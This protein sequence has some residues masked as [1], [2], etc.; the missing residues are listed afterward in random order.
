MWAVVIVIV[1]PPA[2]FLVEPV[3]VVADAVL[4]QQLVKLLVV[5]AM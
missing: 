4:V 2:Q 5:D 3:N 1:L